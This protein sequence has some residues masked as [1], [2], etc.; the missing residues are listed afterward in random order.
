MPYALCLT[1]ASAKSDT[2]ISA[3]KP[4]AIYDVS[5]QRHD[6]NLLTGIDTSIFQLHRNDFVRRDGA[7]YFNL[8][9]SGTAAYPIIFQPTATSG[10]TAGFRQFDVYRYT[11]DSMR[12]YHALRPYT[13]I[14]YVIGLNQEQIFRGRFF[15]STKS[16]FDYGTDF[17]YLNSP[18]TY[19]H[20]RAVDAGFYLYG[21]YHAKNYRWNVFTDLVFNHFKTLDNAGLQKDYFATDT[22]FFSK[23]LTPVKLDSAQNTYSDWN[24]FLGADYHLGKTI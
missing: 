4:K 19:T 9:N 15:H 24:W 5:Y 10:L 18:G 7:E 8:G 23:T 6:E 12:Y 14:N 11:R 20:Q 21:K 17:Y 3:Q 22:S 2:T 16:G 13:E 1:T